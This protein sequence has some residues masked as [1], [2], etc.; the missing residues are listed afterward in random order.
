MA[1]PAPVDVRLFEGFVAVA[2]RDG[3]Y[4]HTRR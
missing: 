3:G 4:V 1:Y 2:C